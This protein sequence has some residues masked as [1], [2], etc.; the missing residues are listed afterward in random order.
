MKPAAPA[1]TRC[2]PA[3][4]AALAL[5]ASPAQARIEPARGDWN[6]TY[7]ATGEGHRVG[8]PEAA[9]SLVMFVSYTCPH[10]AEFEQQSEGALR[11]GYIHE[12]KLSV[13]VRHLIRNPVDLA[14][15]LAAECGPAERFFARH[16]TMLGAHRQWMATAM[17]AT[18]A[19]QQRWV[20]GPLPGRMRA[21][22]SDL[23]FYALMERHGLTRA[24]L[25]RCLSDEARA[26]AIAAASQEQS[27]RFA[28]PG[29]PSFLVNGRLLEGVHSWP[30]LRAALD[31]R[32]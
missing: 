27:R 14:A 19:Q 26:N 1:R 24:A 28:I 30:S 20:S 7:A 4:A 25:D 10:C 32:P 23:G 12:G 3:L 5:A 6:A 9:T 16:R 15:A 18:P 17:A 22:A 29:T 31:A 8:N 21:I 11:L 2:W 13:E